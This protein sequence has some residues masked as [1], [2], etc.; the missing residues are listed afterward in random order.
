[1]C[2]RRRDADVSRCPP[3]VVSLPENKTALGASLTPRGPDTPLPRDPN[4]FWSRAVVRH[5]SSSSPLSFPRG[6]FARYPRQRIWC[7][8]P[9]WRQEPICVRPWESGRFRLPPSPQSAWQISPE[10]ADSHHEQADLDSRDKLV[11]SGAGCR[12][13]VGR[14]PRLF[15]RLRGRVWTLNPR[16]AGAVLTFVVVTSDPPHA[17][18]DAHL[19]K[20]VESRWGH[21]PFAGAPCES[22]R[23]VGGSSVSLPPR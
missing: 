5:S 6:S 12:S 1:M 17:S 11:S 9:F 19:P 14:P 15:E 8:P 10:H 18:A 4:S 22:S 16:G 20:G 21:H 13:R 2:C 3:C 7:S 23:S